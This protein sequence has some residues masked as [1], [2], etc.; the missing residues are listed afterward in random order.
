MSAPAIEI[1]GVGFWSPGYADAD[2]LARGRRDES[3]A[4]PEPTLGSR[5]HLRYVSDLTSMAI[6]ACEQSIAGTDIPLDQINVLFAS[7]QGEIQIAVELLDMIA[8]E[9]GASPARFMNSVH[10]TVCGH[11]SIAAKS[12]GMFTALAGS[13]QTV[14]AAFVEA[15]GLLATGACDNLV[16]V[17]GD[18]RLPPPVDPED[19]D[20][21]AMALFLRGGDGCTDVPRFAGVVR[22]PSVSA[23]A[24]PSNLAKNPCAPA[25]CVLAALA[26]KRAG[27]VRLDGDC[28]EGWCAELVF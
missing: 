14:S 8:D 4:T 16:L 1:H 10:N 5:R 23:F 24:A 19:Y 20:S 17:V 6:A 7:S 18:E 26:E 3:I 9:G 12:H 25:L 21:M 2:S 27:R 11:I 15:Y 13:R 22:D 28:D